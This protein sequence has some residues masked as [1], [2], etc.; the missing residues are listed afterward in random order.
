MRAFRKTRNQWVPLHTEKAGPGVIRCSVRLAHKFA[1]LRD[2]LTYGLIVL[3]LSQKEYVPRFCLLDNSR[4]DSRQY[5]PSDQTLREAPNGLALPC[6]RW[7]PSFWKPATCLRR[8]CWFL[9]LQQKR[10]IQFYRYWV[11][12][13][14]KGLIVVATPR[15]L[16]HS[17]TWNWRYAIFNTHTAFQLL[18]SFEQVHRTALVFSKQYFFYTSISNFIDCWYSQSK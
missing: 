12:H 5:L 13:S 7:K 6:R 9:L 8:F 14:W 15:G 16:I 17:R 3:I 18:L 11:L 2:L 1:R 10:T 4:S